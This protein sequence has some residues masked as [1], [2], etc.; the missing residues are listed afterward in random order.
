MALDAVT[1]SL[2]GLTVGAVGV[3]AHAA[4]H[5]L[6]GHLRA[7]RENTLMALFFAFLSGFLFPWVWVFAGDTLTTATAFPGWAAGMLWGGLVWAAFTLPVEIAHVIWGREGIQTA[8]TG[9]AAWLGQ[10]LVG[11]AICGAV[12]VAI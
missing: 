9:L 12:L 4:A 6:A 7:S 11:G 10:F 5:H 8:T 3:V 2:V 1:T